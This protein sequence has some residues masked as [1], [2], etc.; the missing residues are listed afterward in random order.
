METKT[1]KC[2]GKYGCDQ[3]KSIDQF[4]KRGKKYT[5]SCLECL[6]K[7]QRDLRNSDKEKTNAKNRQYRALNLNKA[8]EWGNKSYA[9]NKHKYIEQRKKYRD[10]HKD[11]MKEYCQIYRVENADKIA[12]YENSSR[13]KELR[14]KNM[15]RWENEQMKNNPSYRVLKS[16]RS[17]LRSAL[18]GGYKT[19]S[20]IHDLGCSIEEFKAYLESKFY[21]N[22]ETGEQMTWSNYGQ[23]GWHIDH[24]RPLMSFNLLEPEQIKIACHYTNLQPMWWKEN[25]DKRSKDAEIWVMDAK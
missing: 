14:R 5:A 12:T 11:T 13:R 8:R 3:I 4:R 10:G 21:A 15:R 17:R 1:K 2:S 23:F 25:L 24:I 7:R 20:T 22:P 6:R 16:L 19:G 9:K 18:K